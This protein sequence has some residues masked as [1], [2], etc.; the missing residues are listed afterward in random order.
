MAGQ[1]WRR[2][3]GRMAG[4]TPAF[5]RYRRTAVEQL[6]RWSYGGIGALES[7]AQFLADGGG[8]LRERR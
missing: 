6:W 1:G 2:H 8:W 7:G 5:A 4:S 3:R